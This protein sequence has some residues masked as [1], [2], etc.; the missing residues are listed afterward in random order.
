[1]PERHFA[2][3]VHLLLCVCQLSVANADGPL[4]PG[5][6]PSPTR[7]LTPSPIPLPTPSPTSLPTPVPVPTP[8]PMF[9]SDVQIDGKDWTSNN[10][11]T[12]C[13]YYNKNW[14]TLNGGYGSGWGS[15]GAFSDWANA[16]YTA[17]RACCACGGGLQLPTG[18]PAAC[19]GMRS[20]KPASILLLFAFV[21]TMA[22]IETS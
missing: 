5:P 2:M 4:L 13:D 22:H 3:L 20:T 9:C 11:A 21:L 14:C 17:V 16:G 12:C 10:G 18:R 15:N 8:A 6:T 19:Y 7:V 1:M